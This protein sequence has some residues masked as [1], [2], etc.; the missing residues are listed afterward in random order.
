MAA[1]MVQLYLSFGSNSAAGCLNQSEI[2]NTMLPF[3]LRF[4]IFAHAGN[5]Y[6]NINGLLGEFPQAKQALLS[7]YE[8]INAASWGILIN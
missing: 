1:I 8:E 4:Y 7:W 6:K 3:W 5:S 2:L